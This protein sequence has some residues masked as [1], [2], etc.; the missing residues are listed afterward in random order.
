VGPCGEL[1]F[2]VERPFTVELPPNRYVSV[3]VRLPKRF[4]F[5]DRERDDRR[6]VYLEEL[7]HLRFWFETSDPDEL[8]IVAEVRTLGQW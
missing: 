4:E 5:A 8:P 2:E 6:P 3:Q 7:R 1:D